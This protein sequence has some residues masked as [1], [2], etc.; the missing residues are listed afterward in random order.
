M[1]I[2]RADAA[3]RRPRSTAEDRRLYRGIAQH[4]LARKWLLKRLVEAQERAE[5]AQSDL[6]RERHQLEVRRMESE[7]KRLGVQ[8]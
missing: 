3:E 7:L 8:L 5:A 6:D 4:P 2:E 1:T